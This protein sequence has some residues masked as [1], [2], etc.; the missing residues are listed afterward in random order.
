MSLKA[1][2]STAKGAAIAVAAAGIFFGLYESVKLM[3]PASN[4]AQ[5]ACFGINA[6]K[7]RG[8]CSTAFNGCTGQNQCKGK[9]YLRVTAKECA[10]QGGVPLEGSPADPAKS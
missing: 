1:N 4:G 9:G 3:R 5:I 8:A 10:S 6:C 7:G 2:T